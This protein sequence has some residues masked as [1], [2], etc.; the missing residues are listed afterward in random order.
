[1]IITCEECNSSFNVN[2]SLIKESGSKVRC[3]KCDSVFVAYPQLSDDELALESDEPLPGRDENPELE[4]F[5]SSI[6]DF[7]SEDEEDEKTEAP[8]AYSATEEIELNLDDF[9]NT[10]EPESKNALKATDGELELDLDFDQDDASG[11]VLSEEE[12]AD[13]ELPDLGDLEDLDDIE[14]LGAFDE[15]GLTEEENDSGFEDLELEMED[16]APSESAAGCG[17]MSTRRN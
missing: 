16:K 7:L 4:D 2:D 13:D 17:T 3:S 5:D 15:E 9:D 6:G 11:S 8:T 12:A 1:M 14:D 10:L